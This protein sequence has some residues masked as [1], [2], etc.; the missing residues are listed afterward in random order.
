MPVKR[1]PGMLRTP[2][3]SAATAV[4]MSIPRLRIAAAESQT[5]TSRCRPP[6]IRT[7]PTPEIFWNLSFS[8]SS[9]KSVRRR[10]SPERSVRTTAMI[11]AASRSNF[12]MT[13]A[14]ASS[15][16]SGITVAIRSRTS[17]APMSMSYSSSNSTMTCETPS[18][19]SERSFL[20]DASELRASS[21]T[22]VTSV[23]IVIASVPGMRVVTVTMGRSTSGKR[24]ALMRG[25]LIAPK[26]ISAAETITIITRLRNAISVTIMA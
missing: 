6:T 24:S 16:N 19:V 1:P 11:G 20:T 10:M 3:R 13:G 15:G 17:C 5:R 2:A 9:A 8:S 26:R 18:C 23:S 22:S 21:T 12:S 14:S 7:P 25:K 4:L